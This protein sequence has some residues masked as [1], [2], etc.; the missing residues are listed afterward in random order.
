LQTSPQAIERVAKLLRTAPNV[1]RAEWS[2][3][4]GYELNSS[5]AI[6]ALEY[7]IAALSDEIVEQALGHYDDQKP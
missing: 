7:L 5:E 1:Q 4:S 6:K 3:W 2:P